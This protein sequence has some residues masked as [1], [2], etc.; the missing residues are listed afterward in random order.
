MKVATPPE[1][2]PVPSVVVS[3]LKVT[4]PV[5]GIGP[6]VCDTAA[7]KVTDCPNV[8]GL[9]EDVRAVVV[10]ACSTT[11]VNGAALEPAKL[12]LPSKTAVTA[13][14]PAVICSVVITLWRA[15]LKVKS[16]SLPTVKWSVPVGVAPLADVSVTVKDTDC[17]TMLGLGE[18]VI[19]T[20]VATILTVWASAVDVEPLKLLSPP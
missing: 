1:I 9:A 7:V 2:V 15:G 11:C 18:D 14:D 10:V 8:L 5:G 13:C 19:V 16:R 3:S 4:V 20:V 17:P 6:A 12:P